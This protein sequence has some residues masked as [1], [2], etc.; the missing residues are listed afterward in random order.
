MA[1]APVSTQTIINDPFKT[2]IAGYKK[3][4]EAYKMIVQTQNEENER[5]RKH[6]VLVEYEIDLTKEILEKKQ[7]EII[8]S[9][10]IISDCNEKIAELENELEKTKVERGAFQKYT[11]MNSMLL[12]KIEEARIRHEAIEWELSKANDEVKYFKSQTNNEKLTQL[13]AQD[14][15]SKNEI[16]SLTTANKM[17]V[18]DRDRLIRKG[19][20]YRE[21]INQLKTRVGLLEENIKQTSVENKTKEYAALAKSMA[22]EDICQRIKD[23]HELVQESLDMSS[24]HRECLQT[25]LSMSLEECQESIHILRASALHSDQQLAAA[26]RR[27]KTLLRDA[28]TME[29]EIELLKKKER[30]AREELKHE[31]TK[32]TSSDL[33]GVGTFGFTAMPQSPEIVA[34]DLRPISGTSLRSTPLNLN[35][36]LDS[37]LTTT[38]ANASVPSSPAQM[39][40]PA[41]RCSSSKG[42]K[43]LI[44]NVFNHTGMTTSV[45]ITELHESPGKTVVLHRYLRCTVEY[46]NAQSPMPSTGTCFRTLN[47][48]L[49]N[50]EL[51]DKDFAEVVAW[52][53]LLNTLKYV[54]HINL[55]GNFLTNES[56]I[57]SLLPFLVAVQDEEFISKTVGDGIGS[58]EG[59]NGEVQTD[60]SLVIDLSGNQ[61]SQRGIKNF[62]VAATRL[63][64]RPHVVPLVDLSS[65]NESLTIYGYQQI[66]PFK[67]NEEDEVDGKIAVHANGVPATADT[68]EI[69]RLMM[70]NS[71]FKPA[72][73]VR[74]KFYDNFGDTT[75]ASKPF[76][77]VDPTVVISPVRVLNN[78]SD[79]VPVDVNNISENDVLNRLRMPCGDTRPTAAQDEPTV[80]PRDSL[81]RHNPFDIANADLDKF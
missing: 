17:L 70:N 11:E 59:I 53:R 24:A 29:A 51:T 75:G 22:T 10:N 26:R 66:K 3:E 4:I 47:V 18:K 78:T 69:T 36:P 12:K 35:S 49:S 56:I 73:V 48:D 23:D 9:T 68:T 30:Y 15:K 20:D 46:I 50:C 52:L 28:M 71:H 42:S 67:Q 37:R 32:R 64:K 79:V 60:N 27:E 45:P 5:L 43:M 39:S 55:H 16:S 8:R 63:L 65:T 74:V 76:Y 19:V 31:L 58:W 77:S 13:I 34:S 57:T 80:F 61:I 7:K 21:E 72:A 2:T 33:G 54:K 62:H 41:H 44:T 81:L 14:F 40:S 1:E 6:I 38:I 25:H